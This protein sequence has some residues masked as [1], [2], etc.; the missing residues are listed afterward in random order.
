MLLVLTLIN[1]H[2]FFVFVKLKIACPN[3][4]RPLTPPIFIRHLPS[5]VSREGKAPKKPTKNH[6]KNTKKNPKS[7]T[8]FLGF[9]SEFFSSERGGS[10]ISLRS[11]HPSRLTPLSCSKNHKKQIKKSCIIDFFN[12]LSEIYIMWK[13]ILIGKDNEKGEAVFEYFDIENIQFN[14]GSITFYTDKRIIKI[15]NDPNTPEESEK[16]GY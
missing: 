13:R 8:R 12:Q 14:D 7:S 9:F 2:G 5:Y 10:A 16:L 3:R 15:I 1:L 6:P 11:A 4:L